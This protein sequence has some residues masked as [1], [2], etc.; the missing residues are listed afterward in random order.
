[1]K[2]FICTTLS[3]AFVST[4]LALPVSAKIR[5]NVPQDVEKF[6]QS[7]G[8]AE[9]R[10][11]L[12]IEPTG[13]GLKNEEEA[14]KLTLGPGLQL[15]VIDPE[16]L[17]SSSASMMSIVKPLDEWE[18]ILEKD[19]KPFTA[20]TVGKREGQ[21]VV[22]KMGGGTE[23]L[24]QA[25]SVFDNETN[26]E[27]P[28]L[29]SDKKVRY[30]VG[31]HKDQEV[32]VPDLPV[33]RAAQLNNMSNQ[34]LWSAADI[35]KELRAQQADAPNKLGTVGGTGSVSA[36]PTAEGSHFPF[37]PVALAGLFG[38]FG[39]GAYTVRKMAQK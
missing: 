38:L 22:T 15:H 37:I 27:Q 34:K 11:M 25:W 18:F 14:R 2:K 10:K 13:F 24:F 36:Q 21:F 16:K 32:A 7:E 35:L 6:A 9:S 12:A 33:E 4:M 1:M 26:E 8:L 29:I 28:I 20:M 23:S 31:K 39:I 19:G 3:V 30:L 17:K 5:S